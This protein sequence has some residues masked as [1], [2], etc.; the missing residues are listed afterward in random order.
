MKKFGIKKRAMKMIPRAKA[1]K[2]KKKK[3]QIL[4]VDILT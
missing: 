4:D 2:K 3:E 1:Q